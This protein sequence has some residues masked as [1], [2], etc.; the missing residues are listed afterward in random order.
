MYHLSTITGMTVSIEETNKTIHKYI[1]FQERNDL[2]WILTPLGVGALISVPVIML[3]YKIKNK[4]NILH[5]FT[6]LF[7]ILVILLHFKI[8]NMIFYI[9]IPLKENS[10]Q[11]LY[12]SICRLS[13]YF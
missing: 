11:S 8:S 2:V 5:A 3:C 10:F 4:G 7:F 6:C 12:T 1:S 13:I 9:L